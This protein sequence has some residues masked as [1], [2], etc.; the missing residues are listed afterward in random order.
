MICLR[1][2]K[3]AGLAGVQAFTCGH[4]DPSA[5]VVQGCSPAIM[6]LVQCSSNDMALDELLLCMM[7]KL[8]A[9]DAT[10]MF[11]RPYAAG[12]SRTRNLPR[13]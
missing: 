10:A 8:A 4:N 9:E 13:A 7:Y 12:A 1:L 3:L 2:M 11:Q 5:A 6:F